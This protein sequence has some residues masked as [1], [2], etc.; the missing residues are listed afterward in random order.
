MN[1]NVIS[2]I[3]VAVLSL[4]GTLVG[5]FASNSRT[6][7]LIEY[8]LQMLEK[9]VDQHNQVIDRTYALETQSAVFQEQIANLNEDIENLSRRIGNE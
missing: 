1:Y 7:A 8:R 2:T 9:K 6:K 5:S 3:I 4:M